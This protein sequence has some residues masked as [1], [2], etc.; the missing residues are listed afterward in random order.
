MLKF[1]TLL[2]MLG[3][4]LSTLAAPSITVNVIGTLHAPTV[5]DL[6][7][8]GTIDFGDLLTDSINGTTHEKPLN[9]S[10]TCVYRNPL[11]SVSVAFNAV[12]ATANL[13]PVKGVTGFDL[14]LKREG[15]VQNINS[16]FVPITDGSL[17]LTLTPVKNSD[18]FSPGAFTATAT[19]MVS[20]I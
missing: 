3:M 19:V 20:V 2:L 18:P 7:D 17:N 10:L 14:A 4:P 15:S 6:S 1:L 11:Q 13:M 16:P 8:P 12:G 5:C 9:I